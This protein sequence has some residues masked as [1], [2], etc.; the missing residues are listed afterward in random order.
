MTLNRPSILSLR[1]LIFGVE[2]SLVSTVGLLAG[3]AVAGLPRPTILLT[4]VVL[5]FVEALSMGAGSFL[6]EY[7]VEEYRRQGNVP[8]RRSIGG[9]VVMFFSYFISG[10]IPLLPYI[11]WEAS[12]AFWISIGFS[13]VSLFVLGVEQARLSK[14]KIVTNGVRMF[15]VGGAA[16]LVGVTVGKLLQ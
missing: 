10:F 16:I 8:A 15:L 2:D 4:G 3:I 9:G 6:S 13:L 1:N 14:L 12:L 11:I 7:S 5:I